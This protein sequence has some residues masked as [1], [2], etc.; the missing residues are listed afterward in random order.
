MSVVSVTNIRYDWT[1]LDHFEFGWMALGPSWP[2][3]PFGPFW[4]FLTILDHKNDDSYLPLICNCCYMDSF[5]CLFIFYPYTSIADNNSFECQH[6]YFEF[7]GQGSHLPIGNWNKGWTVARILDIVTIHM[8]YDSLHP[9]MVQIGPKWS[10]RSKRSKIVKCLHIY[11]I[12]P[13]GSITGD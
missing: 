9:K 1:V 3:G 13:N 5:C 2:C 12:S 7:V 4:L 10:K 8:Q 11:F 6:S